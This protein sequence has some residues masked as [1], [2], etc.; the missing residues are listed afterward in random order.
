VLND[1][2]DGLSCDVDDSF[3]TISVGVIPTMDS[4]N[5]LI[6][7]ESLKAKNFP[8]DKISLKIKRYAHLTARPTEVFSVKK[9]FA[10][11]NQLVTSDESDRVGVGAEL[12]RA[13][14]P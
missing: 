6:D 12:F 2:F 4:R 11:K 8:G 10:Q 9:I 14:S 1:R 7:A 5:R 3:S 13:V